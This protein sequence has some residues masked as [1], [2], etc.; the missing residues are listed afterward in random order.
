[1]FPFITEGTKMAAESRSSMMSRCSSCAMIRLA[2][3]PNT[4]PAT[5]P[6][7]IS[8]PLVCTDT[9]QVYL[10][11]SAGK[12][13]QKLSWCP[14]PLSCPPKAICAVPVL[15]ATRKLSEAAWRPRPVGSLTTIVSIVVIS[16]SACLEAIL[17]MSTSG[18]NSSTTSPSLR[19]ADTSRGFMKV[20]S[21]AMAL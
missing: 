11:A 14:P 5:P 17:S 21:L 13:P 15:P 2:M 4:T 3:S 6:P 12:K 10:G 18:S 16:S 1:M 19:I 7:E 9:M 8:P 20:P